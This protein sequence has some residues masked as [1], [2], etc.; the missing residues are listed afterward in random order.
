MHLAMENSRV[1]VLHSSPDTPAVDIY[2]DGSPVITN[3]G[4]GQFSDYAALSPGRHQ[5]Q[6]FPASALGAGTPVIVTSAEFASNESYTIAAVGNLGSIQ[7]VALLDT[8]SPP[9]PDMAKVR[10]FHTSPDAP[11]VDV[12][13]KSGTKLFKNISFKEATPFVEVPADIVDLDIVP[14]GSTE[15]VLSISGYPLEAGYLYTFVALGLLKGTPGFKIVAIVDPV[16]I[17]MPL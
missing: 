13:T 5:I 9:A 16:T 11:S 14:S 3:L 15:P 17:R 8:T 12:Q 7:A 4:F 2:V 10:A 1:R 6:V